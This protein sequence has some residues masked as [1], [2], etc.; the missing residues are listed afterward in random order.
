MD[1]GKTLEFRVEGDLTIETV[2]GVQDKLLGCFRENPHQ[3][4]VRWEALERVDVTGIQL[5]HAADLLARHKNILF[6]LDRPFPVALEVAIREGG[7]T[8][9]GWVKG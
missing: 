4:Q 8:Y 6:S 5:L 3:I 2:R 1:E 7:F 9:L